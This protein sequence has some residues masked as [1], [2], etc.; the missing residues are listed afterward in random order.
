MHRQLKVRA[1]LDTETMTEIAQRAIVF[2][3]S[4]PDIVDRHDELHG[5]VH[6]V[7]SCPDCTAPVVVKNGEMVSLS[8]QAGVVVEE[9]LLVGKSQQAS[10]A[11]SQGE[12]ELVPC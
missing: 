10:S 4:H 6:R 11:N 1:A 5:Q 12:G 7:Y 9:G 8:K 3:L 2:Y